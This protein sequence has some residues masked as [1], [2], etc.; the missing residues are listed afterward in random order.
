MVELEKCLE[1]LD[2][3]GFKVFN[4][5]P[6]KIKVSRSSTACTSKVDSDK[7][8]EISLG[9]LKDQIL[10]ELNMYS[11]A[12]FIDEDELKFSEVVYTKCSNIYSI[13]V[14][15]RE[16]NYLVIK[17][18]EV[19]D[20]DLINKL[21]YLVDQ[22]RITDLKRTCEEVK[23]FVDEPYLRTIGI[24]TR[25]AYE[26]DELFMENYQVLY[27][28]V[29]LNRSIELF[30]VNVVL[31]KINNSVYLEYDVSGNYPL[32]KFILDSP[33]DIVAY[34]HRIRNCDK[35]LYSE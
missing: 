8:D 6:D 22:D 3:Y 31:D 10:V 20:K 11:P 15:N 27:H 25:A 30:T 19:T 21:G 33:K 35:T 5:T 28:L 17:T 9:F 16:D 4:S 32:T 7:K 23:I 24:E 26:F 2:S 14:G 34:I 18:G 12:D 29:G 1:I 13:S